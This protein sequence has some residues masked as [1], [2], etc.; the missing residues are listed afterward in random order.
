M[1]VQTI[2]NGATVIVAALFTAVAVSGCSAGGDDAASG[3]TPTPSRTAVTP[4]TATCELLGTDGGTVSMTETADSYTVEFRGVPRD[5]ADDRTSYSV[6]VDDDD[7]QAYAGLLMSW[8]RDRLMN[9]GTTDEPAA[10]EVEV[11][12]EPEEDGD[13]VRGTFPKV[14]ERPAT[15]WSPVYSTIDASGVTD[16]RCSEDGQVL[17]YTALDTE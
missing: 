10:D 16:H 1:T 17:P 6:Q 7:R 11:D 3:P 8:D 13:V 15:W 2:R 5:A 9:Y 4:G 14:T 12:G